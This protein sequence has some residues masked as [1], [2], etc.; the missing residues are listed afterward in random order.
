MKVTKKNVSDYVDNLIELT[1]KVKFGEVTILTGSNGSG[2]SFIRKML[3]FKLAEKEFDDKM[4]TVVAS[5]SMQQR[6]ASNPEWGGLSG[7]MRDVDWTPTSTETL[8]KIN[9]VLNCTERFIVIDEPEIGMGEETLLGLIEKLN[10]E[11]TDKIVSKSIYGAMIITH[12]RLVVNYLR[13]DTFLN[14]DGMTSIEW[15]NRQPQA[16]NLKELED[17]SSLIF[18]E[19]QDRINSKSK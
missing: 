5:T 12:S 4:K 1:E 18:R 19:I 16:M 14:I 10:K 6:T 3:G 2:K 9:S 8:H 17:R 13:H 15:L 7:I 11:L